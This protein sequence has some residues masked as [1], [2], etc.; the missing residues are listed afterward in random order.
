MF[1]Q[2]TMIAYNEALLQDDLDLF[3]F[4]NLIFTV[5]VAR[6]IQVQN[7]QKI[8]FVQLDFSNSIFQNPIIEKSS[9]VRLLIVLLV[10]FISF[11]RIMCIFSIFCHLLSLKTMLHKQ[12]LA[13]KRRARASLAVCIAQATGYFDNMGCQ[14]S[15]REIQ[16]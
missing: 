2:D 5:Y 7:R 8:K 12:M 15:K 13:K 11:F 9:A 10:K 6:K 3:F 4:S 16:E 14:V 1:F